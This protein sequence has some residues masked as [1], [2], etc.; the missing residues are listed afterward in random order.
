MSRA[1]ARAFRSH[2][3]GPV[4]RHVAAC[5]GEPAALALA[6]RCGLP[7]GA[8]SAPWIELE[9][10]RLHRFLDDA[11]D[12]AGDPLLGIHVGEALPRETWDVLQMSSLSAPTLRA[13]LA[14]LPR[15]V[16]LFNDAVEITTGGGRD[17]SIAHAIPGVPEGLS[18]HG[19]ELWVAAL[20]RRAREATGVAIRPRAVWFAHRA[21]AEQAAIARAL[22]VPPPAFGAGATGIEISAA[23]ADR[24][25]R[26]ADPVLL[27]VLD[28]LV[29]PQLAAL[30]DRR[31]VAARVC[32]A[33]DASL[34]AGV[35]GRAGTAQLATM[36]EVARALAMSTRT[37]QRELTESG[38]S[39]R[40][41]VDHVR[42][43]RA[44]TLLRDD[45][46]VDEVAARLGYSERSAFV[47]AFGRWSGR[48][49][50]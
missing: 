18:R 47:R 16:T 10:P 34:D 11:A 30:G 7:A 8:A 44:R 27:G 6:K 12:A 20:L 42:Q 29:A 50:A 36:D 35:D 49:A 31:G 9:L 45:V 33:L 39:F 37:L 43:T 15:L 28:R 13:A 41:L 48:G 25:L 24:P 14:V 21:P 26:T 3:V 46:P 22:D 1:A 19:N 38:T 17:V 40:A 5:A 2:I 4:L 32:R 23:D